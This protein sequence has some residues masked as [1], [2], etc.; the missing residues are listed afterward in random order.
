MENPISLI[1]F[2]PQHIPLGMQLKSWANWNQVEADWNLLL[3]QSSGGAFVA[4]FDG[5]SV[6][7]TITINYQAAF[8]WI[9]M[10]LVAPAHRGKGIGTHLLQAALTYARRKGPIMLDAT[11]MGQP[12][13]HS[14]GF[15]VAGEVVRMEGKIPTLLPQPTY[16]EIQNIKQEDLPLL[17][18]YD[19][20][21]LQ[22][23]RNL[24]L[25]DF[26]HRA[27]ASAFK[28]VQD[29]TI[30][31]YCLGRAGSQF[32]QIGPLVADN[33]EI[34]IALLAAACRTASNRPLIIDA[35]TNKKH[36]VETLRTMG[37]TIQRSFARMCC[38]E[39]YFARQSLKPYAIAGPAF[40]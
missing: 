26:F 20:R 25:L 15:Q 29:E 38:G 27:P 8:Y 17:S 33:E 5:E 2:E 32:H 22:F 11:A 23:D 1:P 14:L 6:G 13:Y 35:P 12:L 24:L 19:K 34:A 10:V 40:G 7:T 16:F 18:S 28:A 30:I 37:F 39:Q 9:G 21:H 31:G 3:Q 4:T 36:W